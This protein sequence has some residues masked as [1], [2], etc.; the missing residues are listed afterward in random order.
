MQLIRVLVVDDSPYIRRVI[1][2]VLLPELDLRLVGEA[3]D[4]EEAVHA[5][6]LLNP[7][8]VL[9]DIRL[10]GL[11]GLDATRRIRSVKPAPEVL[12][13]TELEGADYVTRAREAGASGLIWKDSLLQHL[14]PSVRVLGTPGAPRDLPPLFAET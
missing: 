6:A 4:G 5:T 7:H 10:P 9:M 1:A 8:V 14:V 3:A 11:D 2:D 13:I 12:V